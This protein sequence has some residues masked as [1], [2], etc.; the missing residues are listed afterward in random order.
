MD[1]PIEVQA[2]AVHNIAFYTSTYIYIIIL[3][4]FTVVLNEKINR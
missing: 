3:N 2:Q 1:I 4:E